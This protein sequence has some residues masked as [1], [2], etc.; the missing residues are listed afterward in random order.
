M[1]IDYIPNIN[2][3]KD[4]LVRLYEFNQEQAKKLRAKI[5]EVVVLNKKSLNFK[6]LDFI[7]SRN[8]NLTLRIAEEDEGITSLDTINF[9]CDLTVKGYKKMID[10]IAPFCSKETKGHQYLY[11]DIDSPTDFL[12]S[13]AG[14]W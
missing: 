5:E 4:D 14:T 13:P 7:E 9:Y 6:D 10:L 2:A 8:C 12:F 3:Y 11:T 1:K